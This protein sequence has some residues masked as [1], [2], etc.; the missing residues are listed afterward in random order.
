MVNGQS[1]CSDVTRVGVISRCGELLANPIAG[2]IV[3][4]LSSGCERMADVMLKSVLTCQVCSV[5]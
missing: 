2:T 5:R 3:S 1:G 4:D